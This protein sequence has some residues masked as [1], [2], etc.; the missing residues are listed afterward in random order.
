ML[1]AGR[2]GNCDQRAGASTA[3]RRYRLTRAGRATLA[4][5]RDA[6]EELYEEVG[7]G[8][9]TRQKAEGRRQKAHGRRPT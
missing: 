6:L 8:R 1:A 7:Q 2:Y 4:R 5:L 3:A 9:T